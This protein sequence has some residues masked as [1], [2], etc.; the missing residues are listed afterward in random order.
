MFLVLI[1]ALLPPALAQPIIMTIEDATFDNSIADY[2]IQIHCR[3]EN[4]IFYGETV[5]IA[6]SVNDNPRIHDLF[7]FERSCIHEYRIEETLLQPPENTT[8]TLDYRSLDQRTK[9]TISLTYEFPKKADFLGVQVDQP[10][11][12]WFLMSLVK[13]LM[14]NTIIIIC[15]CIGFILGAIIGNSRGE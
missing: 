12:D 14:D 7:V 4:P 15:S 5:E 11:I 1:L 9:E 8:I 3:G 6:L 2:T 13:M 10:I